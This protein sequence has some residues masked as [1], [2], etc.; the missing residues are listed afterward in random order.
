MDPFHTVYREL[1]E[2]EKNR[3]EAIKSVATELYTHFA[4]IKDGRE[5]SLAKTKLEEAVMWAVKGLTK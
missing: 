5:T 1:T 2:V 4:E 3:V